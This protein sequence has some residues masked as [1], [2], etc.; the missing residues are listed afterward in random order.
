MKKVFYFCLCI[1]LLGSCKSQK[2]VV[3]FTDLE[4]EW[5]VTELSGVDLAKADAKPKMSF[6]T[7]EKRMAA[8]AGC[9][10]IAG[11]AELTT[12]NP[13]AIKFTGVLATRK[14]C[15][16]NMDKET[17]LLKALDKIE[18]F[19]AGPVS[20]SAVAYVF[21][22]AEKEKLFVIERAKVSAPQ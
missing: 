8:D 11:M 12:S 3:S 7:A 19:G 21:Y 6:N 4:G 9:N 16:E 2:T 13:S 15:L 14:F 1:I 20:P 5:S 18:S 17:A 22:G 10:N